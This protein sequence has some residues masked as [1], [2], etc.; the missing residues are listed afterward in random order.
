MIIVSKKGFNI[1]KE[2]KY[3]ILLIGSGGFLGS[4]VKK[5]L[6]DSGINF[7]EITGKSH[8]DITNFEQ[9]N[10]FISNHSVQTIINCAAFVGGIS[11]GFKYQA[12][13]LQ[14][15]TLM[16][17][18]IYNIAKMHDIKYIINPISNCAYPGKSSVY[19][20]KDFWDGPPHESV[21]NYALSK[22]VFVAM[23]KSYYE[24]YKIST[25]SVVL[26][27][28]YG[29][30]DHFEEERSHALGALVKKIYIAKLNNN[31]EVEIWGS[32][33]PV[34]EWLYVEDGAKSLIKAI[35][36]SP[37]NYL[38]NVGVNKGASIIE[39]AEM[40]ANEFSWEGKF[41]L[42]VSRPDGVL[43]KTVDGNLGKEIL[44]W[45]P[46]VKLN[47]GIADTVKWYRAENE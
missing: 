5:Q 28:M 44:N 3:Q 6:N 19:I 29:P 9:F 4:H 47:E 26:S 32:G 21:F 41:I 43:K 17:S 1:N 46:E 27:N 31:S 10:S 20:E 23:G 35:N 33:K 13:L 12:D 2:M 40:I 18:N 30:G 34:R 7:I 38:F 22:R 39:I 37:G 8:V 42:D 45:S 15:N 24:Q 16:A 36:L 25:A 14:I 11:F